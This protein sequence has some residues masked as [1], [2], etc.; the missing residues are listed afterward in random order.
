MLIYSQ[1]TQQQRAITA[2]RATTRRIGRVCGIALSQIE[3]TDRLQRLIE[4]K[5]K[6]VRA[7]YQDDFEKGSDIGK[8]LLSIL[9]KCYSSLFQ[10]FLMSPTVKANMASDVKPDQRMSDEEVLAQITT[11]VSVSPDPACIGRSSE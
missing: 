2:S 10:S 9:G 6:A 8:D 11:F 4:E 7:T 5:K 1:P 3:L